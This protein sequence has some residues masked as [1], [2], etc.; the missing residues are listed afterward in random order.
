MREVIINSAIP[1]VAIIINEDLTSNHLDFSVDLKILAGETAFFLKVIEF[2]H[3]ATPFCYIFANV[4]NNSIKPTSGFD[5]KFDI[6]GNLKSYSME[7]LIVLLELPWAT[8]TFSQG[9]KA[10]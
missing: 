5:P 7:R 10:M 1:A 8:D 2:E 6:I 3:G 4:F 9:I